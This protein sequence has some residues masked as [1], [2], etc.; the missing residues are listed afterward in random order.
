MCHL[1]QFNRVRA[2]A[3]HREEEEEEE[4]GEEAAEEKEAEGVPVYTARPNSDA[5][6][7]NYDACYIY[8]YNL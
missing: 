3:A 6:Y 2:R 5:G 8:M 1:H 7:R 4:E